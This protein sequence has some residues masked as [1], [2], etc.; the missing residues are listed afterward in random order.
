MPVSTSEGAA[1]FRSAVALARFALTS[2]EL[3]DRHRRRLLHDAVWVVTEGAGRTRKYRPRYRSGGVLALDGLARR[4]WLALVRHDHV[5]TIRSLVD[6]LLRLGADPEAVLAKAQGCLVTKAEHQRLTEQD[7]KQSGWDRYL[8]AGVDVYD[9]ASGE[10]VA[11]ELGLS[12]R[13]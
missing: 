2:T 7:A 6:E 13:R 5:V 8:A 12:A 4:D 9:L 11:L 1:D 3:T 10:P